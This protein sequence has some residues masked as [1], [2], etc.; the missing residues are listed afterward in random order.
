MLRPI[1]PLTAIALTPNLTAIYMRILAECLPAKSEALAFL[2][3]RPDLDETAA[4][5]LLTRTSGKARVATIRHITD[6]A[7]L[8][9][10]HT[11]KSLRPAVCANPHTPVDILLETIDMLSYVG[12]VGEDVLQA[13]CNPSTP[14]EAR[15]KYLNFKS[16][17]AILVSVSS[18][19]ALSVGRSYALVE[20]NQ[21]MLDD[22]LGWGPNISR[23]LVSRPAPAPKLYEHL[24]KDLFAASRVPG[25][26]N[27]PLTQSK[28]VSDL[29]VDELLSMNNVAADLEVISRSE[30]DVNAATK[31]LHRPD[32]HPEPHI[33]ARCLTV[34]GL[35][36]LFGGEQPP[37]WADS[38]IV[39][40][41]W[42]EPFAT[43]IHQILPQW[44][45]ADDLENYATY[46]KALE[47]TENFFTNL[48]QDEAK[49]RE[50]IGTLIALSKDWEGDLE[51]LLQTADKL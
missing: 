14:L 23:A 12:G 33:I 48:Y 17:A 26:R 45:S 51:S 22:S 39:A 34:F 44:H 5:L 46:R 32:Y 35:V 20:N 27:H 38:R 28:P 18:P 30:F 16:T 36:P 8:R 19:L 29:S 3:T 1:N 25:M 13:A 6:P 31:M 49:T 42:L 41:S 43:Y 10:L 50:I 7:K 2:A 21:W 40:T 11:K 4:D 15:Q 24:R 47:S 9:H 37:G